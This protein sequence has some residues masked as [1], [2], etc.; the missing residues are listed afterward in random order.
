MADRISLRLIGSDGSHW[1]K[2]VS[3]VRLPGCDGSLGV[4]PGHAPMLCAVKAG[5][6]LCRFGEGESALLR[7]SDGIASVSGD[8]VTLLLSSLEQEA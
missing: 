4:L 8:E 6:L 7:I 5:E 2:S 3:Y 1:E